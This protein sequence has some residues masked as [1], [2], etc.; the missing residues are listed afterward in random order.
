[1]GIVI[2]RKFVCA[3]Y[4][5]KERT[6]TSSCCLP[7]LP[8]FALHLFY[9]FQHQLSLRTKKVHR[10][11]GA[12]TLADRKRPPRDVPFKFKSN[13]QTFLVL[14]A[15]RTRVVPHR[16]EGTFRPEQVCHSPPRPNC[17]TLIGSLHRLQPYCHNI[18]PSWLAEFKGQLRNIPDVGPKLTY[19]TESERIN[20]YVFLYC[21]YWK[22]A[23]KRS[24]RAVLHAIV[25]NEP[26]TSIG[27][28]L[29]ARHVRT[30]KTER[31]TF[32]PPHLTQWPR[33]DDTNSLV[34]IES[35]RTAALIS[36]ESRAG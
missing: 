3:I 14:Q 20:P 32:L 16:I 6:S 17:H 28:C 7:K 12:E 10:V 18:P 5:N 22:N 4:I 1:M 19:L 29:S 27:A 8:V 36:A 24:R 34:Y 15:D 26:F 33:F 21:C 35:K 2:I 9:I 11:G 23:S 25:S 31:L 13:P 30:F